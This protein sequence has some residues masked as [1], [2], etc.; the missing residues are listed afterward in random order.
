M[1]EGDIIEIDG[2]TLYIL[3]NGELVIADAWPAEEMSVLSRTP[4]EGNAIAEYLYGNRLAIISQKQSPIAPDLRVSASLLLDSWY[5]VP[6]RTD[7]W[8]TV[9]DISSRQAPQVVQKTLLDGTYVESRRIDDFVFLVLRNDRIQ[10]PQPEMIPVANIDLTEESSPE[11]WLPGGEFVYE[12]REQY[13]ERMRSQMG[14]LVEATLPQ[15]TSYGADGE[16][17]RAGLLH[18]P[19]DLFRPP[20]DPENSLVSVVSVNISNDEPGISTSAGIFTSGADKI[21]GSLDNLYIFDD[22]HSTEDGRITQILKFRWSGET[23]DVSFVAKGHVP[24][25]LLNQFSA[26]E[27]HDHL[28]IATTIENVSAGNFS[29]RSENVL[30]VLRDDAGVME[31]VGGLKNLALDETIRSVRFFGERAFVTTF[32]DI[33]PLFAVDLSEPASPL[34]VGH[35]TMPGFNSYMQL[36][37]AQ[38]ILAVGRN[39]PTGRSGP[40]QVSL[41]DVQDLS[42]P[43]LLDQYTFARF[44]TSEAEADHHAFGWFAEHQMLAVPS[45]RSYWQRV[46]AD[47]DGYRESREWVTE[48]ALFLFQ[49]D[50]SAA[51]PGDG[52]IRLQGEIEHDSPVRRSAFIED[53]LFSVAASSTIAVD[54]HDTS[55]RFAE[56]RYEPVGPPG[57]PP[58][59]SPTQEM[60]ATV[61]DVVRRAKEHLA[62]VTGLDA[63]QIVGST[64]ESAHWRAETIETDT[65]DPRDDSI[66]GFRVVLDVGDRKYLY[67]A[68]R[69]ETVVLVDES[70][71][72]EPPQVAW[73][74]V[75]QPLDVNDDLLVTPRDA[76]VLVN[77]LN[78]RGARRLA[79]D[80]VSRIIHFRPSYLL[81]V[82]DDGYLSP[83]DALLI[84]NRLNAQAAGDRDAEGESADLLGILR[85]GGVWETWQPAQKTH[86]LEDGEPASDAASAPQVP[87]A[88]DNDLVGDAIG[89]MARDIVERT[90]ATVE[91]QSLSDLW[92]AYSWLEEGDL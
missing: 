46:D 77:D 41:F 27:F 75:A 24:G 78:R 16:L 30:F 12:S 39:T 67:H 57:S 59:D 25:R 69:S 82:N 70:F 64:V 48:D 83:R 11:S 56:I 34:S 58:D 81:D 20:P 72:F 33:D 5:P 29:R 7:T 22:Q 50:I 74:N 36:I 84:I 79:P 4:V 45:A 65:D 87:S 71:Q 40:A 19:E 3:A 60:N 63:S 76:L 21:Y 55:H 18:A 14:S 13:V 1:D 51:Q 2:D 66:P 80:Q 42:Q 9:F 86:S 62:E 85:P 91:Q 92:D 53:V 26:D 88:A 68:D 8:L 61:V 23:G 43:R 49:I 28:R 90:L 10:L 44:S 35:I 32:R 73:H 31:F 17:A 15:F 47:G 38:H 89:L 6:Q 52:T 54:I 37:D